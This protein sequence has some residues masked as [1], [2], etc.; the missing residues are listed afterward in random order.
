MHRFA[1]PAVV[2]ILLGLTTLNADAAGRGKCRQGYNACISHM[3]SIGTAMNKAASKCSRMCSG[4]GGKHG[5]HGRGHPPGGKKCV[6]GYSACVAHKVRSGVPAGK[7][8]HICQRV[9]GH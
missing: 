4:R 9:C 6:K 8:K 3:T 2:I 7:A 5:K 1:V